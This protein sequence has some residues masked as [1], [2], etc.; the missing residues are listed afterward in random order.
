[1]HVMG[2]RS[3]KAVQLAMPPAA[4][5][6]VVADSGHYDFLARCGSADSFDWAALHAIFSAALVSFLNQTLKVG[7]GTRCRTLWIA[8]AVNPASMSA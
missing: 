3:E 7:T 2:N 8:G 6:H 5:H 4:D 1:M